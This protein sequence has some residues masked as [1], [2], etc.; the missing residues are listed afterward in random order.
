M[1]FASIRSTEYVDG[2]PR[3]LHVEE[4]L[5][6]IDFGD[7]EPH[8]CQPAKD[9]LMARTPYFDVRWKPLKTGE[10]SRPE[11]EGEFVCLAVA[12]GVIQVGEMAASAGDFLLLPAHLPEEKRRMLAQVDAEV[13]EIRLP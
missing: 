7:F 12:Q 5:Q 8:L 10:T 11:G 3:D 2:K 1:N 6:C 4:S 13:L 9:G